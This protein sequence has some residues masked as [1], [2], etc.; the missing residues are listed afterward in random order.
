M[1]LAQN[2]NIRSEGN[3]TDAFTRDLFDLKSLRR[4]ILCT[5]AARTFNDEAVQIIQNMDR[6][7]VI[8]VDFMNLEKLVRSLESILAL[9]NFLNSGTGRGGAHGFIFET[10][11]MLSTVK[12]AKG[13]TLLNYLIFLLERDSPGL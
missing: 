6:F 13:N 8:P 5:L 9:G 7:A 11:A 4:K 2:A 12:D 1:L 3:K 10:F